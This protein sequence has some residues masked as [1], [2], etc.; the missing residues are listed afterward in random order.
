MINRFDEV[1]ETVKL[2]EAKLKGKLQE[3]LNFDH[4]NMK[5]I[6]TKN[7]KIQANNKT[8]KIKVIDA[9]K[10]RI[11]ISEVFNRKITM[12][13]SNSMN[14]RASLQAKSE[15]R[16]ESLSKVKQR[17]SILKTD[18]NRLKRLQSLDI[19]IGKKKEF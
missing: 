1:E 8:H 7:R 5:I 13:R 16:L 12:Q 18:G 9:R 19:R 6:M 14:S 3:D 2:Y 17:Q 11:K 10:L 4:L 15:R